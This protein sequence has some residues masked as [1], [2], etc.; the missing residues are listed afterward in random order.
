MPMNHATSQAGRG[1]DRVALAVLAVF[2]ALSFFVLGGR[3]RAADPK[4]GIAVIESEQK[5]ILGFAYPTAKKVDS[6]KATDKTTN[7][8]GAFSVTVRF[9][10]IDKDGDDAYVSLKFKF[11]KN[12]KMTD[13]TETSRSS[14]WAAFFTA[15][16]VI[17]AVKAAIR[18]DD[19]L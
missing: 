8:D 5:L 15:D 2:A 17:E 12:G 18:N 11:D 9:N 3:A 14:F 4:D 19:K 10:Y 1:L 13:V 7:L 6:L 16:L